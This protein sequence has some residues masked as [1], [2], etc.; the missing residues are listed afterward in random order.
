MDDVRLLIDLHR[1][2]ARLGPGSD[3]T[4]RQALELSGLLG[5]PGL[6]VADL[7]CGTGASAMVLAEHLDARITAV[8][9]FLEFLEELT[10]RAEA[11]GVGARIT[12]L[13]ASIDALPFEPQA[14][15]AIWSE[16]AIY[17]LGFEAGVVAWRPFLKPGG[18]LAVSELT[19]LTAERPPALQAHWQREYPQVD[20]ASGK[21][22]VL[23]RHGFTP[24]GYFPLPESCWLEHYYRPLQARFPALLEQHG[25]SDAAR[26]CVE[27][28]EREIALY[29]RYKAHVSYGFYIARK[30]TA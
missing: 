4:T 22:A 12:T 8:D 11:R 23:E 7:G 24:I 10:R 13:A 29:E 18:V 16:G 2:S 17:H 6:R 28:E 9:L 5:R 27:A 26:A 21:L 15:D 30:T 14:L 25:Q 20:L 1:P 19:W 3:A